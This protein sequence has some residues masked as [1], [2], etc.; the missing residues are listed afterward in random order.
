MALDFTLCAM[1]ALDYRSLF[2]VTDSFFNYGYDRVFS[3]RSIK[4]NTYFL[5]RYIKYF[6]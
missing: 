1:M 3:F 5:I 4:I 2:T 6:K